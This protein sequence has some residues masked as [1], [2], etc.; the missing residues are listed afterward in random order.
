MEE[1]KPLQAVWM[2][3]LATVFWGMSFPLMKGLV[4]LQQQLLPGAS[5]WFITSQTLT[6]RFGLAAVVL[7]LVLARRMRGLTALD[8]KLG[9]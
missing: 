7:A 5:V 4:L 2:L 9:V 3:L 6:V 1:R 8:M